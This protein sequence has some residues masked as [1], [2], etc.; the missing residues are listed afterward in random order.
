MIILKMIIVGRIMKL[1]LKLNAEGTAIVMVTHNRS[2]FEKYHGRVFSCRDE[3]C[4][5]QSDS[6]EIDLDITV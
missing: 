5:E 6:V 3:S 2:I 1:L 4:T